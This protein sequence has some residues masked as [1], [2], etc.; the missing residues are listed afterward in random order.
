MRTAAGTFVPAA[1]STV[2]NS[3]DAVL[4]GPLGSEGDLDPLFAVG[5]H[6]CAVVAVPRRMDD[7]EVDIRLDPPRAG[8]HTGTL[9]E[10]L[11]KSI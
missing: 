1:F 7:P 4:E 6:G 8:S 9:G 10:L 2:R 11:K 5:G 3:C